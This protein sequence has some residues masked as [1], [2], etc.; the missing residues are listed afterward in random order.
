MQSSA[1]S[2]VFQFRGDDMKSL[3]HDCLSETTISEKSC[4]IGAAVA[5][6]HIGTAKVLTFS[7]VK[8]LAKATSEIE[9]A[10]VLYANCH[11]IR[12]SKRWQAGRSRLDD[13]R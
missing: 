13:T 4:V 1:R 12:L 2:G 5:A 6:V 8:T 3:R 11:R 10:D 7:F 9:Q